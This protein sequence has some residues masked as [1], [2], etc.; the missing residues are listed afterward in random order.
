MDIIKDDE[1]YYNVDGI[2]TDVNEYYYGSDLL[3]AEDKMKLKGV[4]KFGRKVLVW[5]SWLV[6]AIHC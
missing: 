2:V 3:E 6:R 1:K 4:P 5:I